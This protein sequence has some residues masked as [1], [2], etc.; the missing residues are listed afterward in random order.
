MRFL[1]DVRR[2]IKAIYIVAQQ[3]PLLQG[4]LKG[5]LIHRQRK[6]AMEHGLSLL[7][8]KTALIAADIRYRQKAAFFPL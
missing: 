3:H 8:K 5:G 2:I 7:F 4:L 6:S 1:P